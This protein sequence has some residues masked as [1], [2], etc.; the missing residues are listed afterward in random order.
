MSI[1]QLVYLDM[2][3]YA[4]VNEAVSIACRTAVRFA[5]VRL[6][7]ADR[8]AERNGYPRSA[9]RTAGRRAAYAFIK[10]RADAP[11]GCRGAAGPNL[12]ADGHGRPRQGSDALRAAG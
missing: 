3:D 2:P 8:G 12:A 4:S 1:Y 5:A 6:R 10:W 7:N 11:A 9:G